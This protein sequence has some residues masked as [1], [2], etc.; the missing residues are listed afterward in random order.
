MRDYGNFKAY[1]DECPSSSVDWEICKGICL[2][3]DY[4]ATGVCPLKCIKEG[5]NYIEQ[6]KQELAYAQKKLGTGHDDLWLWKIDR[7]TTYLNQKEP[8]KTN[9]APT[10]NKRTSGT[11]V[12]DSQTSDEASV[13][14][15]PVNQNPEASGLELIDSER[16]NENGNVL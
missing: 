6:V 16:R 5:L 8:A 3:E 12:E 1:C 10:E 15:I 2:D 14:R 13:V 11:S 7:L 9:D 4:G